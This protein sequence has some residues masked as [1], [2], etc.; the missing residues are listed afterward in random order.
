MGEPLIGGVLLTPLRRVPNPK[1]D[2][3]HAVKRS[4][5]GFA[6]FAEAYF[7]AALPG[8][9]KGWKRHRRVT[10][11]LVVPVGRIRFVIHDD[12]PDSPTRG[13]FDDVTLGEEHYARL[14]V[15]PGLWMAF[16]A[17]RSEPG[18]L[19]N[20]TN[21]EHDPNEADNAGLESFN[22]HW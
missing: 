20:V 5:P 9:I 10:L 22:F 2:V 16:T 17:A 1:G 18:M 14:T 6:G 8:Q 21:E 15:P 7:S 12:R 13:H 3:M 4:S 11:N 19:L